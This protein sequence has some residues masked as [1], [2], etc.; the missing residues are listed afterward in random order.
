MTEI[1]RMDGK[2]VF[3]PENAPSISQGYKPQDRLE[4]QTWTMHLAIMKE[5]T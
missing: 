1:I 2:T 4:K 5:Q 3:I